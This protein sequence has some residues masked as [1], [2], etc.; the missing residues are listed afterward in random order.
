[1]KAKMNSYQKL[2]KRNE[3]LEERF[4]SLREFISKATPVELEMF[5]K[6]WNIENGIVSSWWQGSTE[7]SGTSYDGILSLMQKTES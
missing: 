3:E 4:W 6:Q 1:M 5:K 7:V 2:K